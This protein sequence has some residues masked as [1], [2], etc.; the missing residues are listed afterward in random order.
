MYDL[1]K[2]GWQSFQLLCQTIV[3]EILGQTVETY[4][5]THD[6]GRDGG[7]TGRWCAAEHEDL[8]GPFVIQCK[9]TAKADGILRPSD[10]AD[11][12]EKAKRLVARGLCESYVLMTNA[13]I[14]GTGAADIGDRLKAVGVKRFRILGATW[15][16]QQIRENKRLRMLVPRVY[17]LGDLSQILDERAYAQARNI[18]ESM[19]EDLAKVVVTDAH[20]RAVSAIDKHGFVL[21][22][23]EPASGK[24]TIASYLSIAALDQWEASILKLDGPK[25]V[26]NRWNP[27]EP[28]QF[29]WLDDAF[30]VTQYD[31]SRVQ[32]WNHVLTDIRAMLRSGAKIVMTSRDYIYNHA[33]QTLK[34]NAFPLLNES[35]VVIDVHE[36]T[37]DE[38][39]R[40]LYNHVKMGNQPRS[41]RTKIKPYLEGVA[42]HPRFIPETARQLADPFFTDKLFPDDYHINDHY[43]GQF[44]ERREELLQDIVQGLDTDSQAALALVFM[45]DGHLRSPV[46][47]EPPETQALERL[48]SSIGKS[49][50][51]LQSLRGSLVVFSHASGEPVWE[52]KHPTIG[53]AYAAVLVR[54]PEHIGIFIQGTAPERLVNQVTCGDVG[55][56]RALVVPRPLF[57]HMLTKLDQMPISTECN[58]DIRD[59]FAARWQLHQFLGQR[60]SKEFIELY[61]MR[62]SSLFDQ[63]SSDDIMLYTDSEMILAKRLHEFG[64]LPDDYR[65]KFVSTLSDYLLEG[66]YAMALD[67][68][69]GRSL[70]TDDEF[71]D[72]LQRVRAELLPRL[73]DLRLEWESNF[74]SDKTPED[75]MYPIVDLFD[76]LK[77]QFRNDQRTIQAIDSEISELEA[78]IADNALE[79]AEMSPRQLGQIETPEVMR[80]ARSVFD[81]ID[82]DEEPEAD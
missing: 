2:L 82:A 39:R 69:A 79:E 13:G 81:D 22:I 6:G 66:T 76:S 19:R 33:R 75:H 61:L 10:L 26:S 77:T 72:L 36:L 68:A 4:L 73:D 5:D 1:H 16:N 23:G 14:T 15:I 3:R 56:K 7:F 43:L 28:S 27:D 63:V 42:S 70:F 8:S 12:V 17:G 41:F 40:I 51:A 52:F 21:L 18:L 20:R 38:K 35:Q 62:N 32:D 11:E 50:Q 45:R 25:E 57:P 30:G 53:D 48:G 65:K 49:V 9:F 34:E 46:D 47:L 74:P 59:A 67:N 31:D 64:L 24:T 58:A 37:D 78:W 54:N 44:V 71:A 60:C 55:I 80:G 29:F